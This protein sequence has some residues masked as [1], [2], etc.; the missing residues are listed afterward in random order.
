MNIL[1]INILIHIRYMYNKYKNFQHFFVFSNYKYPLH[2]GIA[3]LCVIV[4]TVT[5][6]PLVCDHV[7]K[8]PWIQMTITDNKIANSTLP[9]LY[10]LSFHAK[11]SFAR[12]FGDIILN[13][14]PSCN[15]SLHI[16]NNHAPFKHYLGLYSVP[17][18]NY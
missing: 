7:I 8:K 2:N 3:L 18:D 11:L 4:R 17:I 16:L 9:V 1:L 15:H 13:V 5:K 14:L 10:T 12:H 6:W